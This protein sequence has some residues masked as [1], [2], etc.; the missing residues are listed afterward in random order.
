M[1]IIENADTIY[2]SDII[3]NSSFLMN[4][5]STAPDS[6]T[7]ED[8]RALIGQMNREQYNEFII[9]VQNYLDGQIKTYDELI[10]G[11]E[12]YYSEMFDLFNASNETTFQSIFNT[13]ELNLY[14]Q[15]TISD[16]VMNVTMGLLPEVLEK[17]SI[18]MDDFLKLD[19]NE[20]VE[21]VRKYDSRVIKAE[22]AYNQ[23]LTNFDKQVEEKFGYLGITRVTELFQAMNELEQ[24][25]IQV[26]EA[27]S[28]AINQKASAQYDYLPYLT[29][30]SEYTY[31]SITQSDLAA[32]EN[33]SNVID[34]TKDAVLLYYGYTDLTKTYSFT[35]YQKNHP[36]ITPIEY[37]MMVKAL[38]P[39]QEVNITGISDIEDLKA[40]L[41]IVDKCP[42]YAKTYSYLYT[43]DPKQASDFIKACKYEINSIRGQVAAQNFLSSLGVQ[44]GNQDTLE[45]IANTLNVSVEGLVDGLESFGEGVYYS[46]ES[47][48]VALGICSENRTMSAEEYKRLFILQALLSNEVKLSSG[49]IT[50][51]SDGTYSNNIEANPY[52]IIDF[53]K[54]YSGLWL[55][56][57][58][59][60]AQGIGNM[61]PSILISMV[62]PAAG[63]W[64]LGIS[65]GGNAYHSAMV[66][67]KSYL[68]SLF[69]GLFTGAS[70]AITERI[71]G[72]LPGLS[73]TKV[74]S[75]TTYLKAV[76]RESVQESFQ[77]GMDYLYKAMFMGEPLPDINDAEGWKTILEDIGTQGIYGGITA[78]ILQSPSLLSSTVNMKSINKFVNQNGIKTEQQQAAITELRNSNPE[79]A[80]LTDNEIKLQFT[81]EFATLA[82]INK[83]AT[84]NN[85][86]PDVAKVVLALNISIPVAKLM[87]EENLSLADATAKAQYLLFLEENNISNF[88]LDMAFKALRNTNAELADLTD[89]EIAKNNPK[90][91]EKIVKTNRFIMLG[92]HEDVATVMVEYN[93]TEQIAQY[94]L[95]N[96]C[97]FEEA[98]NY[99]EKIGVNHDYVAD[100]DLS[101]RVFMTYNVEQLLENQDYRHACNVFFSLATTE[102][103]RNTLAE[104]LLNGMIGDFGFDSNK[105]N[106]DNPSIEG[107]RRLAMANLYL[108]NPEGFKLL[109]ENRI[110][111]FHGT[112]GVALS[113]ILENGILSLKASQENNIEVTTGEEWSR[114]ANI[115]RNFVSLADNMGIAMYYSQISKSS[116]T[117]N[118]PMIVGTTVEDANAAGTMIIYSDVPEVG[119]RNQ[120]P[121]SAVKLII[122]PFDKVDLVQDIV[123]DSAVVIGMDITSS[124]YTEDIDSNYFQ[125]TEKQVEEYKRQLEIK[126]MTEAVAAQYHISEEDAK[127][128]VINPEAA[129]YIL[130]LIRLIESEK[131]MTLKEYGNQKADNHYDPEIVFKAQALAEAKRMV[132]ELAEPSISKDMK[133]L[134]T[135]TCKLDGFEHRLKSTDSIARKILFDANRTHIELETACDRI[136]DSVRYTLICD[137]ETFTEDVRRSM[138]TLLAK[139]YR[140]R[141]FRNNFGNVMYKGINVGLIS[142][143]G[144][145]ME[146][147]FHTEESHS[148]KEEKSHVI[149]EIARN[150][151]ASP[152][153]KAIANI[154]RK[155]IAAQIT[156]P[157]G[158]LTLLEE[159]FKN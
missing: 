68:D 151:F 52:E 142:P 131:G 60:I 137:D 74:T 57:K 79:F 50:L 85:V 90:E 157:D 105:A 66:D 25:I 77:G 97:S 139:G 92:I 96:N 70:E 89:E 112:N 125:I 158:V 63:M 21:I 99:F 149:Y 80:N 14:V 72:G 22:E 35:Q 29:E 133:E 41:F 130:E 154:I 18:T 83:I 138:E 84:E 30:F 81:K 55:N 67:G 111:L 124:P 51:N 132:A 58:Y 76:G 69:Y 24:K 40:L 17:A 113:S 144:V 129:P 94:M 153:A 3:N 9:G 117:L 2:A 107:K 4:V 73:E 47:L 71:L 19:W 39:N 16:E 143:D 49:L 88:E 95:Q 87:V 31:H 121:P 122:V 114:N 141:H 127:I 26:K 27:R 46:I 36:D 20:K 62:N 86:S 110:N 13:N 11:Y 28:L 64:A 45:A 53:T 91:I 128:M 155:I 65:A 152:E 6:L 156:L 5:D 10:K 15:S 108:Q 104:I 61:G 146:L 78:G 147:Q 98:V 59:S 126:K 116:G 54:N 123:G 12:Q 148:A 43:I 134:E 101:H 34:P 109:V 103:Q 102:E 150:E 1:S 48:G 38:N 93:T 82:M 44:D 42:Q 75:L 120:L 7:A 136:G 106:K 33:D 37:M 115:P 8:L 56:H 159:M 118:F 135:S 23:T 32:V 140:V 119:V 100:F 145:M